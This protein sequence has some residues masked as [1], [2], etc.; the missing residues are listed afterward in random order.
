MA[1]DPHIQPIV[2]LV[3][4]GAASG[5]PPSEQSLAERREAY[6][7]LLSAIPPG[8]DVASV[9]ELLVEGPAGPLTLRVYRPLKPEGIVV[10]FH[11]GGWTIGD[12]DTH[13]EPCREIVKQSGTTVVSVDYR[14]APESP[15]PAAIDDSFAAL[16]WVA[17]NR[18][19][20]AADDAKIAVCGDSAGANI[21]AAV[22]LMARDAG[23]PDIA[24]QLLV[25]PAVDARMTEFDSL[26]RNGDGYVLTRETMEWFSSNYLLDDADRLDWRAS[27]LLAD[28]LTGLPPALIITA[29]YDPLHDEGV[30][31]VDALRGAGNKVVHSDYDGMVHIFFQL[32]P[33]VPAGAAAVSEVAAA[34]KAALASDL[35]GTA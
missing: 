16:R 26:D 25:Y 18:A 12:L 14:L 28:D 7:K 2:D 1:L 4:N 21:A 19:D 15:F 13:D 9:S 11:G 3:N 8:P 31:Y 17:A 32:G 23:G 24:A 6:H 30:A 34:A 5:P 29:E 10:F 22:C 27:P 20:L 33:I 35:D